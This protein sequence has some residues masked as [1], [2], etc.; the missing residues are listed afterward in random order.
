MRVAGIRMIPKCHLWMHMTMRTGFGAHFWA[1]VFTSM[2]GAMPKYQNYPM[3]DTGRRPLRGLL[4]ARNLDGILWAP[5][6]CATQ[7]AQA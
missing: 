1:W 3:F 2:P 6:I 7:V 4:K 5:R